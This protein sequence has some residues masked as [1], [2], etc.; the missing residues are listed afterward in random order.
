MPKATNY[1]K[2][3]DKK[4]PVEMQTLGDHSPSLNRDE[5]YTAA[6]SAPL[7]K[8]KTDKRRNIQDVHEASSV[9]FAG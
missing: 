2:I 3:W 9:N 1:Q 7:L 4:R 8:I 5:S 6:G